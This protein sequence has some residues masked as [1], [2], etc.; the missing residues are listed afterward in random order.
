MTL[1]NFD[2]NGQLI[3]RRQSDGYINLTQMCTANGKKI[4][5]FLALASTKNYI[6]QIESDDGITASQLLIVKKG[7]SSELFQS[8][9][10]D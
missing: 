9:Y 1:A 2:Y 10:G 3:Q 5:H 4:S 8:P 6:A 7:N